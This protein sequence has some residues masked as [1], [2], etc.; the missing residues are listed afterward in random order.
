MNVDNVAVFESDP[1]VL[2][3]YAAVGKRHSG[4]DYAFHV[5]LHRSGKDLL[6]GDVCV[7]SHSAVGKNV[8]SA[9]KSALGN[10][11]DGEIGSRKLALV[12]ESPQ[13]ERVQIVTAGEQIGIVSLPIGDRIIA[14]GSAAF[15]DLLPKLLNGFRVRK[16]GKHL[17]CPFDPGHCRN[18]P[19][20]LVL[21][22]IHVPARDSVSGLLS[23]GPFFLI[24]I[25]KTVR[26]IGGNVNISG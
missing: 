22:G 19:L 8:I 20:M 24:D 5:T 15:E 7:I 17:P 9:H 3:E 13:L 14:V 11:T 23:L 4:I 18:A 26:I 25:R 1:K 21:H 10:K 12:I 6:G 2:Y 16:L